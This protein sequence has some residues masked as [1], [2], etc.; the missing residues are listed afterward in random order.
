MT[1]RISRCILETSDDLRGPLG[2]PELE[3]PAIS[4]LEAIA[5]CNSINQAAKIV[6]VSYKSAWEHVE[7]LN[8]LSSQALVIRMAGGSGGGGTIL[9]HA[10]LLFLERT[11]LLRREFKRFM[12][13]FA[14]GPEEALQLLK[15]IRKF[16]MKLSARNIWSGQVAAIQAGAVNSIVEIALKGGDAI[17]SVIT[18][19]SVERLE[20]Q[21]GKEVLAIVKAS[22]VLIGRDLQKD[23]LSARNILNGTVAHVVE[24]AVNDEITIKLAGGSTVTAII[25][26]ESVHR[27]GLAP[28]GEAQAVIKASSVL[29]AIA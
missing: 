28:G 29:L 23:H 11:Q 12:A 3:G 15:T 10:G 4:L 13:L 14:G 17:V 24:G 27:L 21:P 18:N 16:E 26:R 9:T 7:K 5:E 8:N 25:T 1:R 19:A 22:S 20:L 2:W 6:G